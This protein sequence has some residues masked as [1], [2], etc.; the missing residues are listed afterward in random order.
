MAKRTGLP[1]AQRRAYLL[2]QILNKFQPII[3]T[4]FPANVA[5]HAAVSAAVASCEVLRAEIAKQLPEGV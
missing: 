1:T 4:A 5:L 2:C 3:L